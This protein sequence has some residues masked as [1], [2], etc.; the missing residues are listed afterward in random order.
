VVL[1]TAALS[2][3]GL[4]LAGGSCGGEQRP[5]SADT[6]GRFLTGAPAGPSSGPPGPR[7]RR[8]HRHVAPQGNDGNQ[9]TRA[10]P[11]RTL[12]HAA[13][14]V[15]PGVTV[16][17]APGR[18][19]GPLTIARSG[20]ARRPVR[21]VS[22]RRWR[23]R[24]SARSGGSLAVVEIHGDHVTFAG[25]DVTGAAAG[26]A[27]GIAVEGSDDT[28]SGNRVH[29][30]A[31][32]CAPGAGIVVAG[33]D[34]SQRDGLVTRNVVQ[35]IGTGPLDGSCRLMHGIYAAV[36]RVTVVN[37]IVQQAT[38][39]GITSWHAARNLVIANNLSARNGGAGILVGSGDTGATSAG[40]IRTLVSN[41]IAVRNALYGITES[42]DGSHP[43][44]PGN[45]YL[46]N[47]TFANREGAVGGLSSGEILA[48]NVDAEPRLK[49]PRYHPRADSPV[50][51]AG[52][53]AGA[54][55]RDFSGMARQGRAVDIGP[56]ELR[57]T[58]GRCER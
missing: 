40:N 46:N 17:V 10:R 41:N 6:G 43:V 26:A 32:P 28:V 4:G 51:D 16:H 14:S 31:A 56:H 18:Y 19:A 53:C 7:V 22:D 35:R 2:A 33:D 44:G 36:P 57:S 23:G 54:P 13:A 45:R 49:P 37:N 11:W 5:P 9:G 27:T 48:G 42:S 12:E 24:I 58:P 38:G 52:T 29:D 1:A 30:L 20:T 39:D 21:F 3:L 47:L 8:V 50:V 34:Y 55:R 25:F 15:R